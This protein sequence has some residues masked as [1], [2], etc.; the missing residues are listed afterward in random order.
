M[1]SI[2]LLICQI[3]TSTKSYQKIL[4]KK[5]SYQKNLTKFVIQFYFLFS[6]SKRFLDFKNF[7]VLTRC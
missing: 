7:Y 2:E 4:S 3:N 1:P 6:Y 5:K